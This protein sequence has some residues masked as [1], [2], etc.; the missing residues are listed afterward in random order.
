M[1]KAPQTKDKEGCSKQIN[2]VYNID[3]HLLLPFLEL[4]E[5]TVRNNKSTNDID[6]SKYYGKEAENHGERGFLRSS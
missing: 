3:F 4:G 2:E 6:R 1:G 5:H